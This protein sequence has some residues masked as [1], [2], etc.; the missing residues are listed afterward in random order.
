MKKMKCILPQLLKS[1][2]W[3]ESLEVIELCNILCKNM[4]VSGKKFYS[5]PKR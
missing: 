4:W 1:A 2:M 3:I 5:L